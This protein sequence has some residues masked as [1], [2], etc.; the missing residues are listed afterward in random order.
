MWWLL[1]DALEVVFGVEPQWRRRNRP[2][3]DLPNQ[4]P[5]LSAGETGGY[6]WDG[7]YWVYDP[8]ATAE[9][10]ARFKP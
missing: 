1:E 8:E 10:V 2:R 7:K 9:D 4:R 6:L 5:A 3:Y